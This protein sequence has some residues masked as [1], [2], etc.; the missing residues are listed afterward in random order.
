MV[1]EASTTTQTPGPSP[2]YILV[3]DDEPGIRNALARGLFEAGYQCVTAADAQEALDR[4][5]QGRYALMLCDIRM[6]GMDGLE[7]LGHAL[8]HDPDMVVIMV[9]ALAS[10]PTALGAIRAG[11]YDYVTKP[12]Q[13]TEVELVVRRALDHRRLR[14]ENRGYVT[15]LEELVDER[16]AQVRRIGLSVITSL[17]LALEAK[18]E[19]THDHSRRVAELSGALGT[20]L[21]LTEAQCADLRLAGMLHDLGK[22]GVREAVLHKPSQLSPDEYRHVKL[23]PELGARILSPLQD[24]AHIVPFIRHHHERWDGDGYPDGLAG[25]AIP[26]GARILSLADAYVAMREHRPYRPSLSQDRALGELHIGARRQFDLHVV[27]AM[28]DLH[29]SGR[30]D[31]IDAHFPEDVVEFHVA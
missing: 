7:L 14:L 26:F 1:T 29:R 16:T 6:P 3:V 20:Q 22:I 23:H 17:G 4:L 12:F 28:V 2:Q 24:L 30:L 10:L 11:A 8:G 21:G 13:L 19:W 18:D 25:E 31:Q 9:T 15:H 27:S 5:R